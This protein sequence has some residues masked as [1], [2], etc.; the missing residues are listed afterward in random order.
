LGRSPTV[1]PMS[2][3]VSSDKLFSLPL[4]LHSSSSHR[5]STEHT[6]I[7]IDLWYRDTMKKAKQKRL[8]LLIKDKGQSSTLSTN[9]F[10]TIPTHHL[11]LGTW[12]IG[13]LELEPLDHPVTNLL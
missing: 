2:F 11:L 3:L 9:C 6:K 8:L 7:P 4:W 10:A 1:K 12:L 5:S 13:P